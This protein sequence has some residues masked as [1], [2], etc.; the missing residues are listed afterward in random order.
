[1][2]SPDLAAPGAEAALTAPPRGPYNWSAMREAHPRVGADVA[3]EDA[4]TAALRR[5]EERLARDP[6]SLAWAS[7][8][9]AHRKAGR[10][11]EAIRLCLDGLARFPHYTTARLIL[12]KAYL[13]EGRDEAALAQL[14]VIL[15]A[16]PRVAEAH[17]LAAE[18]HRRAG[19]PEPAARHLEALL[20]LEPGDREARAVL[21]LLRGEGRVAGTSPLA[22]VLADDTFATLAF[23]DVCLAQGLHEEAAQ[24]CLRRLRAHPDDPR[25]RERLA[26]ALRAK[27]QRRKGP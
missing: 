24:I 11:A 22:A 7:L 3:A 8:A 13:D 16:T 18:I 2:P 15:A 27:P 4:A 17:R 26:R 1:M 19:Q 12:A 23:A 21:E 10:A 20:R 6:R 5:Q 14:Q 25:A 9:D